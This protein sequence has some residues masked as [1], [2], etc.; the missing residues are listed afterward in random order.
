M[1]RS[2]KVRVECL[3]TVTL[4]VKHAAFPTQRALAED[5]GLA[6]STVRN[7]LTGKPVYY[8]TFTELCQ[9]LSLEWQEIADLGNQA[10]TEPSYRKS[11]TQ[12]TD[13]RIYWGEAVDA[14]VFFGRTDELATLEQ[15]IIADGCRMLAVLG[16]GG[17]GKTLLAA[18]LSEQ[19]QG[20]FD[21]LIWQSLRNAPPVEE[22]LATWIPILSQQQQTANPTSFDAQIVQLMEY[23]RCCR[24]LLVLDNFDAILGSSDGS[25]ALPS[26][27][28]GQYREG[29]EN[30]GELLR[31]VGGER[32]ASC[33]LLTSREKPK[34]LTPLEGQTLP[35]RSLRLTGLGIRE[36]QAMLQATGHLSASEAEWSQLTQLYAGNPLALKVVS[37]MVQELFDGSIAQFLKQEAI[38][39]GDI[40]LLLDE[41]FQRLS[42]LEKQI[43]YW[44]AINREEMSL[45]ELQDDFV[46]KPSQP[47]LLEALQ[48]LR[49]RSLIEKSAGRFTL[50]PVVMEYVTQQLIEQIHAEIA[51]GEAGSDSFLILHSSSLFQNHALIK[52]QAKDYVRE[53]QT[54]MILV[55]L[56]ERL[57]S[58][59]RSKRDVEYRLKQLL[60][61]LQAECPNSIG[62]AGGNIINLLRQLKLDL[63]GYDFSHLNV[64]QAYL[65]AVTLHRVSFA[66]SDVSKSVF[67]HTFGS[68]HAVAFSPDGKYLAAGDTNGEIRL[69][70]VG[71]S[72][73]LLICQGHT[74]WVSSI[75][76]SPDGHLFA[77]GSFD[78][79]IK[80]W[81]LHSG[82]CFRT[83]LGHDNVIYSVAFSPQGD[84]IASGSDDRTVKL[85]DVSS[86]Q[87]LT[88]LL[89]HSYGIRSIA[90]SPDGKQLA[91]G[92]ADQT[93]RIW[94]VQTGQCL[95]TLSG[96][97]RWVWSVAFS[98][99]GKW[100]VSGGDDPKVRI[101][102]VQ[103]G[104]CLNTL[105]GHTAGLRSLTF[106]PDGQR[107]ASGG[108]D[109]TIRIW[110]VS[111]GRCLTTL[112][113][114]TS[115]I[116][117]VA[118]SPD[119]Q[120]LASGGED[121]T[122]KLWSLT[123]G[124]CLKTLSGY[125]LSVWSVAFAPQRDLQ[126]VDDHFMDYRLASASNDGM[127]RLWN[128][129][130]GE[131]LN[132]AGH[133]DIVSAI[134]YS[135]EGRFLASSGGTTDRTVRIWDASNGQCLN[136]LQGHT[137][138]VWSVAYS[139]DGQT[140][141]SSSAD[142]TV[143]LWDV[144]TGRC[145]NTLTGHIGW[146]WSVAFSLDGS[147]L[148]SGSFDRTV[149]IWDAS[150]GQCL[151]TLKGHTAGVCSVAFSPDGHLLAS[152]SVDQT[153]RL[154]NVSDNHC[155][156]TLLGHGNIVWCV[157]FNPQGTRLASGSGD[158]TV[159][160]WNVQDGDCL[161]TFA[162]HAKLVQ[163][164]IFNSQ[165]N[166]L[167]SAS[168]DGTIKLWDV[169]T[170]QCLK[171][172]RSDRPYE[173]MNI[174]GI[175]GITAAQKSTLKALGAVED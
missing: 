77:S 107:L 53:S 114:H 29:Y 58:Q 33:L 34:T 36:A 41:Q 26:P 49:R 69:W 149:R 165:G 76:F 124:K 50:Q 12:T 2:L 45:V 130:S 25:T 8:S 164:V 167:A 83:L 71:D 52:A 7:F 94:D 65:Q 131:Y 5:L 154:W 42:M 122:V 168:Q 170:G 102:D 100:L 88:T 112:S 79:T 19:L 39:F 128:F 135:P 22:V 97:T 27:P 92:C 119:G 74:G 63:S 120:R 115:W 162:G 54:R 142:Q 121:N 155:L 28:V 66:H 24:T 111:T 61:G 118:F 47:K 48:A 6:L 125:C 172:L 161:K 136:I 169:E 84:I 85:W 72:Q 101:W 31:R 73:P 148:A 16:I 157:A 43:M 163:S 67:T 70:Q 143:K 68:I 103:T 81:D 127:V 4:A 78:Q 56:V 18:R 17:I 151:K 15:W 123:Q 98:P 35:V 171:T 147:L 87:Y 38:A 138:E 40:N 134:A 82:Q 37:S 175:S 104:Q 140:L 160:I 55:P 166:L 44:L 146:V 141:V 126:Q 109:R 96:H 90:F 10:S 89:V 129:S 117:S 113:G 152:G 150:N 80:L 108:A 75:A 137:S 110:E 173:G 14:S 106:S 20:E 105:S 158:T 153:V 13:K 60:F 21:C 62:Y 11:Q 159:K 23:L 133:T 139:P 51:G 145:L 91:T 116:W 86:G 99:D 46:F 32:H 1:P 57:M 93:A 30:Y 132:L 144:P 9:R 64:W 3:E 59:F 156:H 95:H 174:T